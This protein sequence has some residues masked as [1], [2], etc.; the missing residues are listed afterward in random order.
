[1]KSLQWIVPLRPGQLTDD[2]PQLVATIT[3]GLEIE[4]HELGREGQ[5]LLRL[6]SLAACQ[7]GQALQDAS[8][9]AGQAAKR[10]GR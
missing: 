6:P 9:V 7:L 5:P 8:R 4:V 1:M 10:G 3:E 2:A